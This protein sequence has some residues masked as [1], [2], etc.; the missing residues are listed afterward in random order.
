M[1]L[2][3]RAQLDEANL[4]LRYVMKDLKG[5][6]RLSVLALALDR[7]PTAVAR[8]AGISARGLWM[9]RQAALKKLRFRLE[10]MGI[11]STADLL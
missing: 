10:R 6:Q 7:S 4:V 11:K 3:R 8:E 9:A 5:N 2:I 1:D